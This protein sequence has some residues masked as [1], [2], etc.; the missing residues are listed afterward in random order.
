MWVQFLGING[1]CG[2]QEPTDGC[3][4]RV[5]TF[6][7]MDTLKSIILLISLSLTERKKKK[8]K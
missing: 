7:I 2:G 8:G 4:C 5:H 1:Q 6:W 3:I